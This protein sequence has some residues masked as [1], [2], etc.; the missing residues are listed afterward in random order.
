MVER[1]KEED[2][3]TAL[4]KDLWRVVIRTLGKTRS[5]VSTCYVGDLPDETTRSVI[6][7]VY[8]REA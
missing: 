5:S 8:M 2:V 1:N 7:F 6:G 4:R 3:N